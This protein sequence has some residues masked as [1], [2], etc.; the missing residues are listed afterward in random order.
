M[1][2]YAAAG[3]KCCKCTFA[4]GFSYAAVLKLEFY[5]IIFANMFSLAFLKSETRAWG[6]SHHKK[7]NK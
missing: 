6:G 1:Q 4:A 2:L 3:F 5:E 7:P